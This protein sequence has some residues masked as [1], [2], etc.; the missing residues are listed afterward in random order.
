MLVYRVIATII[1]FSSLSVSAEVISKSCINRVADVDHKR[2]IIIANSALDIGLQAESSSVGGDYADRLIGNVAAEKS[3]AVI[4]LLDH[5]TDLA[6]LWKFVKHSKEVDDIYLGQLKIT[7][8]LIKSVV[9]QDVN[10]INLAI[11]KIKNDRLREELKDL[12][13]NLS[14]MRSDLSCQ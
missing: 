5:I 9:D 7:L 4:N 6:V 12:R 13:N 14:S 1:M 8:D 11:P 10:Y 3:F 2:A